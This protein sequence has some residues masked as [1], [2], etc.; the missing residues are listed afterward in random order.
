MGLS[1]ENREILNKAS[2]QNYK[3]Q[4]GD[5]IHESLE[6]LKTTITDQKD[7]ASEDNSWGQSLTAALSKKVS[8]EDFNHLANFAAQIPA[9]VASVSALAAKVDALQAQ[10]DAL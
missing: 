4:L 10:V 5:V 7:D 2:W 1:N 3:I 6:N 8:V 9:L